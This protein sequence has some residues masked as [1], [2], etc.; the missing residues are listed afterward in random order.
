M[1]G[2]MEKKRSVGVTIFG[3]LMVVLGIIAV[4]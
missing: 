1:G 4:V 3:F 2:I